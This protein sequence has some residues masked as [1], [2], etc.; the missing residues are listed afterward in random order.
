MCNLSSNVLPEDVEAVEVFVGLPVSADW[1]SLL[2]NRSSNVLPEEVDALELVVVF[3]GL[4]MPSHWSLSRSVDALGAKTPSANDAP[5]LTAEGR[6]GGVWSTDVTRF[7]FCRAEAVPSA[8]G[9]LPSM[10][11]DAIIDQTTPNR[12][13]GQARRAS[14]YRNRPVHTSKGHQS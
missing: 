6:A 13:A 9:D 1:L 7:G 4:P 3:F 8:P 11:S 14:M 10:A 5:S 12:Q 2:C